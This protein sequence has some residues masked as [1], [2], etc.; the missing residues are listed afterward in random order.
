LTSNLTVEKQHKTFNDT[1]N[2]AYGASRSASN[3]AT[4]SKHKRIPVSYKHT[5]QLDS[6][7]AF[8]GETSRLAQK[9]RVTTNAQGKVLATITKENMGHLN[10]YS[11]RTAFDWRVSINN[12]RKGISRSLRVH[13]NR[14]LVVLPQGVELKSERWKDRLTYIHQHC[15]IDLTQ[16]THVYL[17][18]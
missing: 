17:C 3:G 14:I 11:P 7:Y 6:T 8:P 16:V 18:Q 13:T 9:I 15:Q 12:E 10:I 2:V 4:P 5:K 1:L